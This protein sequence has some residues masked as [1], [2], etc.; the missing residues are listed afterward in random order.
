MSTVVTY[1]GV[2]YT[3]PSVGDSAWGVNVSTYLTALATGSLTRAGGAFTLTADVNFGS[4]YG[5]IS[6]YF[7]SRS[8]NIAASG[9]VRLASGEFLAWRNYGNTDDLF[10]TVNSSDQLVFN[11]AVIPSPG[12]GTGN[13]LLGMNSAGTAQEYK[14][15]TGT[16]NQ[17]TVT[18]GTNSI[19]LAL[20]QDIAT[21]SSPTFVGATFSGLAAARL[22][23]T[24]GSRALI[25]LGYGSSNTASTMVQ[26]DG[27][28]NFSA[29]TIT[30]TLSGNATNVNGTVAI[31][32]G[33]TGQT[34]ANAALNA[35]L[36]TQTGNSGKVLSTNG[37][38]SSWAAA[39]TTTL[40]SAH[41]FVGNGSNVAT[42]VALSG[43][44][45]L[46]NAGVFSL[47]STLSGTK[48]WNDVQ[49]WKYS[50]GATTAGSYDTSGN[51]V[52]GPGSGTN[53]HTL[54]QS[55]ANYV[56]SSG[57]G[58]TVLKGNGGRAIL[59]F[60]GGSGAFQG[61]QFSNES[62]SQSGFSFLTSNGTGAGT[63]D[64]NTNWLLGSNSG[65]GH[66]MQNGSGVTLALKKNSGA[67][68]ALWADA[69]GSSN[70]YTMQNDS[71]TLS[72]YNNGNTLRGT[73]VQNG[74]WSNGGGAWSTLSDERLK[75]NIRPLTGALDLFMRDD[76]TPVQYDWI[77]PTEHEG[78][79]T[80][81]WLAGRLRN[82][83]PTWVSETTV[84]GERDKELIPEGP[85][86]QIEVG[87][88]NFQAYAIAAIR[89]LKV[90]LDAALARIVALESDD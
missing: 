78:A 33:G 39:L 41:I 87:G 62:G 31:A 49:T 67:S 24:D 30:A 90:A 2:S 71:G 79:P 26:R 10:L 56:S 1:N 84:H 42:D 15:L 45:S 7:K 17:V 80:A 82:V 59:T 57:N 77:N 11:G 25:S 48:T 89:E 29:G 36:P 16:S 44:G 60:R 72:W 18:H 8:S 23:A 9:V 32:N 51:W 68:L 58:G 65:T 46:S 69:T 85:A 47:A 81:G 70:V 75:T 5:L 27:S 20:P 4:S 73:V 63:I 34:T 55:G 43:D 61:I 52:L 35:L 13:Q 64:E 14:T 37:T 3:V 88:P 28:G 40:S 83:N 21:G 74:T 86:L 38:D 50:N 54:N 66:S 53:G 19:T 76:A 22:V 12:L 6:K